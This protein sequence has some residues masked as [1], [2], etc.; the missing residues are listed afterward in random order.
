MTRWRDYIS[1]VAWERLGIP[2][3]GLADVARE[4]EVWGS[5]LKLLPPDPILDKRLTMDGKN[6]YRIYSAKD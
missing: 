3:S 4:R 2:Q 6:T 5:L 1:S